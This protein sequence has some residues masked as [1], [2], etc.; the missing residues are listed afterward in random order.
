MNLYTPYGYLAKP[1][2]MVSTLA[3]NGEHL[4]EMTQSYLLGNG[5][6]SYQPMLMKFCQPD[7][8]SPFRDGGINSYAYAGNDPVNY[9]DP[10]GHYRFF[11][12]GKSY[13]GRANV[14]GGGFVYMAKHPTEKGKLAITA[15][16]HGS[17]GGLSNENKTLS[18]ERWIRA[19]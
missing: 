16:N 5:Y 1:T 11:E 12:R 15:V 8:L 17:T 7:S 13:S 18:P 9:S 19:I 3:F 14:V 6:R 4:E 2:P 10:S